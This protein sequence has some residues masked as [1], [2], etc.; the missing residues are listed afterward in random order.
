MKDGWDDTPKKP[1][2]IQ[3]LRCWGGMLGCE[4]PRERHD[5]RFHPHLC[6]SCVDSICALYSAPRS[7]IDMLTLLLHV[8]ASM[9]RQAKYE[10][11]PSEKIAVLAAGRA[12]Y[13]PRLLSS[14]KAG[15]AERKGN[16]FRT[17]FREQAGMAKV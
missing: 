5:F 13:I 12:N 9:Y 4:Q 15:E 14:V 2:P 16:S 11:V 1:K 3:P 10:N 17:W 8:D 7:D 6:L